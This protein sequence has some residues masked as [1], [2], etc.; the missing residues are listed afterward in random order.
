VP[1]YQRD[2]QALFANQV[3]NVENT[4]SQLK[5][6]APVFRTSKLAQALDVVG[7]GM[8]GAMQGYNL[9]QQRKATSGKPASE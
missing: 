3:S 8:G 5:S 6:S 2:Y 7:A 4:K 9:K 1:N